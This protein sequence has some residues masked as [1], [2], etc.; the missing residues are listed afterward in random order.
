MDWFLCDS[1]LRHGRVKLLSLSPL[2]KITARKI[3]AMKS[4]KFSRENG[5]ISEDGT[6][7][8]GDVYLQ[9]CEEC[10]DGETFGAD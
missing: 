6:V 4:A 1:D 3:D 9:K 2:Q 5:N 8:F 10:C 7:M